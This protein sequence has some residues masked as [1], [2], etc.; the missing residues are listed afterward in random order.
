MANTWF[1]TSESALEAA[2]LADDGTAVTRAVQLGASANARSKSNVTPLMVAVDRLKPRAV[3]ALLA[4]GADPNLKADDGASA[5]SL[6]VEN[7]RRAPDIMRAVFA[8][9]GDPNALRPNKSP[10]IM[11]FVIDHD[12][13]RIAMMKSLGANLD[14][15]ARTGRPLVL[16]AAASADWDSVWCLLQLG[17]K[18]DYPTTPATPNLSEWL[19][20]A[21]PAP[22]SP[23]Y[24]YK[25][26]VRDFLRSK[27]LNAPDLAGDKRN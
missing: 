14:A 21:F 15:L 18:Y 20:D 11:R 17:A 4:A 23:I 2:I 8:A 22:D 9:G 13:E 5:V 16:T 12:C 1:N 25:V 6:A 24:P 3:A 26:K 19:A 7:Y 27:G 10:V